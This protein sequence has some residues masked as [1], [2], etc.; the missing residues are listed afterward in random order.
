MKYKMLVLVLFVLLSTTINAAVITNGDKEA[1]SVNG[2][3]INNERIYNEI[4]GTTSYQYLLDVIDFKVMSEK[5]AKD[6]R[7]NDYLNDQYEAAIKDQDIK[8]LYDLVGAKDK[9]DYLLKAGIKLNALRELASMD[10]AYNK[11]FT[12]Y[13]K[14]YVYEHKLSGEI[15]IYHLLVSP[16]IT[17]NDSNDP[18]KKEQALAKANTKAQQAISDL[19]NKMS[20]KDAVKK[21]SSDLLSEDGYLG[22]F[23]IDTAKS[24]Q[25]DQSIINEAFS[26]K[27]KTYSSKPINNKYGYEI[28][29]VEDIKPKVT[30]EQA[31]NEIS[32]I[33]YNMYNNNNPYLRSYALMLFRKENS[34][35]LMDNQM[36]KQYANEIIKSKG[37]YLTYDPNNNPYMN[38]GY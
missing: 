8:N 35:S 31:K 18:K 27:N 26:L 9:E 1:F 37:T 22:T 23:T 3:S 33:L 19:N 30:P 5:Y 28:I 25:L 16:E 15:K 17:I 2:Q 6:S 29:Y 38:Y 14:E 10:A 36:S 12:D 11:V 34:L 21:Y 7:L 4:L 32:K 24:K 13:Q 20:F